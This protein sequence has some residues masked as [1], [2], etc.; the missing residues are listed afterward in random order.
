[1]HT[2][3]NESPTAMQ[4]DSIPSSIPTSTTVEPKPQEIG[5]FFERVT[6]R[7]IP[8]DHYAL[9]WRLKDKRS[10]WINGPITE[11]VIERL[12]HEAETSDL[13]LGPGLCR[14]DL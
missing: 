7:Q 2:T 14:F 13:Y 8:S 10:I 11:A 1:M 5:R 9:V 12:A 3:V 4:V 6:L